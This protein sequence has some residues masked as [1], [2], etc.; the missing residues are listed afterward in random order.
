MD[1]L[2]FM[3]TEDGIEDYLDNFPYYIPALTSLENEFM[4]K[5]I[6]DNYNVVYKD[7]YDRSTDLSSFDN[8]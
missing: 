7:F 6:D 4:E 2:H 3:T 1:L 5:K 8:E